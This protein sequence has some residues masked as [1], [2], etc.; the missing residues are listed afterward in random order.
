MPTVG[1]YSPEA[2]KREVERP[3]EPYTCPDCGWVTTV[4]NEV[5][6][7]LCM[8]CVRFEGDMH[9]AMTGARIAAHNARIMGMTKKKD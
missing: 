2:A 7:R 1:E 9:P 6:A 4:S 5:A 8:R 3:I